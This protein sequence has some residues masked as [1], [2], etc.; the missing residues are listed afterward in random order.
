[1]ADPEQPSPAVLTK[2]TAIV[3]HWILVVLLAT[4]FGMEII[5]L[6]MSVSFADQLDAGFIILAAATTLAWL[7]RQLPFQN[8]VLATLGI[9]MIGGGLVAFAA[10]SLGAKAELP[11]G[12][13]MFAS[14]FGP[15]ILDTTPWQMPLVWIVILLN[16]RGTARLILRPWRKNKTYGY[17]LIGLTAL[18][19]LLFDVAFDPF[20]SRVKH[21]WLWLPTNV[22]LTWQGAPVIN[23]LAWGLI[24]ALILLFTAPALI[25]KKPRSRRG[26]DYH[27]LCVWL[28]ALVLFGISCGTRGIWPPIVADAIIGI[29]VAVFAIR[30]AMW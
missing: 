6:F 10:S 13:W 28:G 26:P 1:M 24:T 2:K 30:G 4:A 18:L 3:C 11:F 9:V 25:V 15:R 17:R 29:V 20:A 14:G 27:P 21:Y 16:S 23:F 7:W 8:V 22:P 5:A 19:V 12:P